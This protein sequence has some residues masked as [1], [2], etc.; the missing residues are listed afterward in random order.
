MLRRVAVLYAL[1]VLTSIGAAM[2]QTT[3]AKTLEATDRI[4]VSGTLESLG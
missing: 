2:A 3:D 4:T 1:V